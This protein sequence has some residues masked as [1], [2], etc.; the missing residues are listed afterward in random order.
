MLP[1]E[2]AIS[3][4]VSGCS[5]GSR[6]WAGGVAKKHE[7]STACIF[8]MSFF[9]GPEADIITVRN[10]AAKVMFLHLSVI[11]S[12]GRRSASVHAGILPLRPGIPPGPKP[13]W[14]QAPPRDQVHPPPPDTPLGD[15]C[16]CGR[17]ASY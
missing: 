2:G 8:S 9:S 11:L 15:G 16:R 10:E 3:L 4:K 17:Y 13:P 14:D 1:P 12:T 5:T 7:I 6:N